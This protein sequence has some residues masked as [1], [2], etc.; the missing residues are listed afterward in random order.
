LG[1]V[2]DRDIWRKARHLALDCW[3]KLVSVYESHAGDCGTKGLAAR[4]ANDPSSGFDRGQ[5]E[6][7]QAQEN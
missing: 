3:R 2:S 7:S 4:D 6:F 5:R 1:I